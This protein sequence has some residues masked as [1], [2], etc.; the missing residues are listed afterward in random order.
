MFPEI[1]RDPILGSEFFNQSEHL[2]PGHG[3][4]GQ[5]RVTD[6][7]EAGFVVAVK[8]SGEGGPGDDSGIFSIFGFKFV[9]FP[10]LNIKI[11]GNY[12]SD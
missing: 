12:Q 11:T 5:N 1:G 6:S 10:V 9:L 7:Q 8:F 3:V 4:G 2:F